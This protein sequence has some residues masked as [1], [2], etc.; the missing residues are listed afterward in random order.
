MKLFSVIFET[1]RMASKLEHAPSGVD[2]RNAEAMID[3]LY[4]PADRAEERSP[5]IEPE[6]SLPHPA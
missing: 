4:C 6:D 5:A 1:M 2:A 3:A